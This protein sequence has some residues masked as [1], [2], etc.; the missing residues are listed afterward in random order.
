M[1]TP[2]PKENISYRAF[3]FPEKK[4]KE[5]EKKK[6]GGEKKIFATSKIKDS[7]PKIWHNG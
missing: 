6:G 5:K 4:R 7:L 1:R 2:H 3:R